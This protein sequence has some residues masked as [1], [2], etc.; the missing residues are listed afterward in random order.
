MAQPKKPRLGIPEPVVALCRRLNAQGHGAWVVG[1]SIRDVLM[2][3]QP[4]DWDIA[5]TAVPEQ[6]MGVFRRVLPTGIDHGTVTVLWR[7]KSYEVTTLRG[8]GPYSDGRRPD[9]VFFVRDPNQDLARRDFTVNAIA[10]DPLEDGLVDPFAGIE[11]IRSRCLRAVGDPRKRFAEDGLRVMRAARFA[12]TLEFDVEDE[13]LQAIPES[14][15]ALS[16]VSRERVRDEW[17]KAM[18]APK[19]SRALEIMRQT[20]ILQA[21]CPELLEQVGCVQNK[22][23][24]HDVWTHS[25]LCVDLADRDPVLRMAALLHDLGKPRKRAFSQKSKDYT[26]HG[27]E[28]LGAQMADSW[29]RAYRFSSHDRERIVHLVRHHLVVYSDA[30]K[31]SAVRR[32]IRRVGSDK[33]DALLSLVTADIR[34]KG[35]SVEGELQGLDRLRERIR[36]VL[37][38]GAAL[39]VGQLAVDGNDVMARLGIQP[40]PAVGKMLERLLERVLDNP[41]LNRRE[42]LLALLDGFGKE[43]A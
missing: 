22:C 31:D 15:A 6:V 11:D 43:E 4:A 39:V 3:R 7:G 41:D 32:F 10:Y 12:A 24:A 36:A 38:Q 40:G 26:F 29:L 23:H 16:R 19:P 35:P 8:E 14:V 25:L 17:L 30:W 37:D 5:T 18:G 21:T 28:Q 33:V 9:N 34:A 1:G 2:G 27:H 42:D 20:G 13:T